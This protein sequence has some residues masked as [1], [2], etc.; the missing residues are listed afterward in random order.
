[1]TDSC[2]VLAS[3]VE[4]HNMILVFL[5]APG[6]GK[7]TQ[8][9]VIVEKLKIIHLS[10]GD[11][12]RE[13]VAA[14]TAIGVEASSYMSKGELVPDSVVIKLIEDRIQKQDCK[15]GFI[16]DGFPRNTVQAESLDEMFSMYTQKIDHTVAIEVDENA[17]VERLTGRRTCKNCG[18]G[19]HIKFQPSKSSNHCDKCNGD[20][21]QRNDDVESV[22]KDRL[23]VYRTKTAPL[24]EYYKKQ[25]L[26]R[27][28]SGSGKPA[29][30]TERILTVISK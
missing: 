29:E 10:T 19:F 22:I 5:G 26:L 15:N 16:L 3:G 24:I 2:Q 25:N 21:V 12:L 23:N 11:M 6:S 18:A 30:I 9:K 7:G 8:A 17:L 4:E 1:M 13:A 28:V 20:L 14:K 27:A